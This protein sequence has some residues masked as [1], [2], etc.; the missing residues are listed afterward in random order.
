MSLKD[1]TRPHKRPSILVH[2]STR[3]AST[4][5]K[6]IGLG[7][8][9]IDEVRGLIYT[10]TV[11]ATKPHFFHPIYYFFSTYTYTAW[12]RWLGSTMR[13][14]SPECKLTDKI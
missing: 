1:I 8:W 9:G 10:W 12:L 3:K 14:T 2:I 6:L 5:V 4:L 7:F 13:S 11:Y